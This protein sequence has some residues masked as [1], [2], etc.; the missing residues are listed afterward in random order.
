MW[1]LSQRYGWYVMDRTELPWIDAPGKLHWR[2]V[3]LPPEAND[4]D[5]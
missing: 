2:S 4:V 3:E 5:D 1:D